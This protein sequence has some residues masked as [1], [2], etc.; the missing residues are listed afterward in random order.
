MIPKLSSLNNNQDLWSHTV[1]MGLEI[2]RHLA[3]WSRLS[4]SWNHSSDTSWSCHHQKAW[5]AMKELLPRQIKCIADNFV[6]VVDRKP[7]FLTM[8]TSLYTCWESSWP[9]AGLALLSE[10]TEKQDTIYETNIFRYWTADSARQRFPERGKANERNPIIS[11]ACYLKSF[12]AV[13][14][15]KR[16]QENLGVIWRWRDRAG[17]LERPRQLEFPG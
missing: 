4:L 8:W 10:T 5:L 6:L 2:G 14:R 1:C 13:T 15:V 3:R 11:P 7:Q 17:N 12:Q 16:I 9:E